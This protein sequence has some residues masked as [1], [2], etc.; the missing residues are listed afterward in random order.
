MAGPGRLP[1]RRILQHDLLDSLARPSAT[2]IIPA[3]QHLEADQLIPMSPSDTASDRTAFTVHSF[4]VDQWLLWSKPD[5]TW[6]WSLTPT[7]PLYE[8]QVT[9]AAKRLPALR[10][11][12]AA[13]GIAGVY[14]VASD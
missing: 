2:T 11:P 8:A 12:S 3:L 9:R 10:I 14:D 6:A 7:Q 4:E 5:S 1:A 13:Q